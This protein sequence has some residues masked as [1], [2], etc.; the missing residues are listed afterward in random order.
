MWKIFIVIPILIA[1]VFTVS[2]L[3]KNNPFFDQLVISRNYDFRHDRPI[4]TDSIFSAE[5]LPLWASTVLHNA[6]P[7]TKVTISLYYMHGTDGKSLLY[8]E[9]MYTE[10]THPIVLRISD[11][12]AEYFPAAEYIVE[13]KTAHGAVVSSRFKLNPAQTIVKKE[14]SSN[15]HQRKT[16]EEILKSTINQYGETK[17]SVRSLEFYRKESLDGS[18]SLIVPTSWKRYAVSAPTRML[19]RS[20]EGELSISRT[21]VDKTDQDR[22]TPEKIL[23]I[24]STMLLSGSKLLHP[25]KTLK[26][27]K[28]AYLLVKITTET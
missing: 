9:E 4:G 23:E 1:A 24:Y 14:K 10:N 11:E 17:E 22:Y 21:C 15:P 6:M 25:P 27:S 7:D 16:D 5:H 8:E 3:A 13:F 18:F 26:I 12:K 28:R 19:Y 20:N 2:T